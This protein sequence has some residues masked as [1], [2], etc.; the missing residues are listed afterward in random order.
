VHGYQKKKIQ[1]KQKKSNQSS[2]M[3]IT[4][5]AAPAVLLISRSRRCGAEFADLTF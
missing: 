3:A 5:C 1:R 2:S 4:S